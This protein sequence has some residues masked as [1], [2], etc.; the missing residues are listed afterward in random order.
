MSLAN[1]ERVCNQFRRRLKT[2]S[3][4]AGV[5]RIVLLA[6]TVTAAMLLLDW[7]ARLAWPGRLLG[8][9][10][11]LGGVVVTF[12]WTLYR[13]LKQRWSNEQI[14]SYVD[15][16][17][18][19]GGR[20]MLLDLYELLHKDQVQE[21]DSPIGE[22]LAEQAVQELEPAVE[23]IK[24]AGSFETKKASNWVAAATVAVLVFLGVGVGLYA[25][26]G[27]NYIGVGMQRLFLLS[28]ERWPH[29]T[30]I[31]LDNL[32]EPGYRVP[33][34]G[35]LTIEGHVRG[36]V[37]P[38]VLVQYRS[39]DDTDWHR[40]RAPVDDDGRFEHTFTDV[41]SE[42]A[43][44]LEGGDYRTSRYLVA[45]S[46]RPYIEHVVAS[47]EAVPY[48]RIPSRTAEDGR[49]RGLEGQRVTLRFRSSMDLDEAQFIQR[50]NGDPV[51]TTRWTFTDAN[52]RTFEKEL[53][54]EE[55][56]SYQIV[57]KDMFEVGQERPEI[58]AIMVHPDHPPEVQITAPGENL[59]QT[60]A[61]R[62]DVAFRATDDFNLDSIQVM[63]ALDGSDPVPLPP[64]I[65]G[66]IPTGGR[67][68]EHDFRWDLTRTMDPRDPDMQDPLPDSGTITY[69][70]RASDGREGR[71]PVDS[72]RYS[73]SI[74][75]PAEFHRRVFERASTRLLNQARI[76]EG[77]Q[78]QAWV[79]ALGW[80]EAMDD[81]EL[82]MSGSDHPGHVEN[83]LWA[84]MAANQDAVVRDV[85]EL[86]R[87]LETL[88]SQ[89]E[90]NDM[91]RAFMSGRVANIRDYIRELEDRVQRAADGI[92]AA[93]PVT[94]AD[95]QP[96]P[97]YDRRK[98][99]LGNIDHTTGF[100]VDQKMAALLVQRLLRRLYDWQDLQTAT[101]QATNIEITL[102]EVME[103]NHET[104]AKYIGQSILNLSYEE[105]E[106][107]I[108][109]ARRQQT[110]ADAEGQLESQ[111]DYMI[112]RAEFQERPA[113][114]APLRSVFE[115]LRDN[116]VHDMLEEAAR[117]IEN[118]QGADVIPHLENALHW[119]RAVRGALVRA[120]RDV[121]DEGPSAIDIAM[122]VDV[123]RSLD[124]QRFRDVMA[125]REAEEEDE[126][127][128][129]ITASDIREPIVV[130]RLDP[131]EFFESLGEGEE[132]LSE[133]I[134]FGIERQEDVLARTRF[135][136]GTGQGG[137]DA[138]P[139]TDEDLPRFRRLSQGALLER[140]DLTI[141]SIEVARDLAEDEDA[142]MVVVFLDLSK[143]ELGQSRQ[144]I[145]QDAPNYSVCTQ[146][147]QDGTIRLL[148]TTVGD[149][150]PS[151]QAVLDAVAENRRSA[152]TEGDEDDEDR[153]QV[154]RA[155][156]DD[157][158]Q[159]YV[160]RGENLDLAEAM[161]NDILTA[162]I[163]QDHNARTV[164]RLAETEPADELQQQFEAE[165]RDRASGLQTDVTR[166]IVQVAE[167]FE[168][169]E[170]EEVK[171]QRLTRRGGTVMVDDEAPKRIEETSVGEIIAL[172][173]DDGSPEDLG[174]GD[175]DREGDRDAN[176]ELVRRLE[177]Q[178][179]TFSQTIR[180]FRGLF[181]TVVR[182]PRRI[183]EEEEGP[184]ALSEEDWEQMT[185]PDTIR[186]HLETHADPLLS[187]HIREIMIKQL[188]EE[189][190]QSFEKR[191][192]QYERYLPL[193]RAYF[194]SFV[195]PDAE[196]DQEQPV[197]EGAEEPAIPEEVPE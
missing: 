111:L 72:A 27:D 114:L 115:L 101:V 2:L 86:T 197:D 163:Y 12:I 88:I 156:H 9:L 179:R 54:L 120:G 91:Q 175:L 196:I 155:G 171:M 34:R 22:Q 70:V 89:Y 195:T 90:R 13:P 25:I 53:V 192:E 132:A 64:E 94:D 3:V 183:R 117:K 46:P 7:W 83:A 41:R 134:R 194:S 79:D 96:D 37:P 63:Y 161:M 103:A 153:G 16:T 172:R 141:E 144:L 51:E 178:S 125:E 139:I 110:V 109:L 49:V 136:G 23:R 77:H 47:Y 20:G 116:R 61:A 78:L 71:E 4:K 39:E 1:L 58:Y 38:S 188:D 187:E 152:E 26:T 189:D 21:L 145:A 43:F 15:S 35:D 146:Q 74:V 93:E 147:L 182:I 62:V 191:Y 113:I 24:V 185:A 129:E 105:Q 151:R 10:V 68:Q 97:L 167:R 133:A 17:A 56:G 32:P 165:N 30:H 150:M 45:I 48:A 157:R 177:D 142:E 52:R 11:L 173:P 158:G 29:Q 102:R 107:L 104:S 162:F 18:P 128:E 33:Q 5:A 50:V 59:E 159:P 118:N 6:V 55:S 75:P 98:G 121:D 184:P 76:A 36:Q 31:H 65:T 95:A 138:E 180:S 40:T 170:S 19:S 122:D 131:R 176:R 124:P 80:L 137:S 28:S 143:E 140:Q 87:A 57:L 92:Q 73:I 112:E 66:P 99:Q 160:L 44:I 126:E 119:I 108:T 14:L 135:F 82:D 168:Q 193:L 85:R 81:D 8:L 60:M 123:E 174:I 69:F 42:F 67:M 148:Q 164:N 100:I 106:E 127:E 149:Y 166:R 84:S 130:D 154:K 190:G 186:A 181:P 169:V